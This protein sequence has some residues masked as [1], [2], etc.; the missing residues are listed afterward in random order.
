M[1]NDSDYDELFSD[2]EVED[3]LTADPNIF[4]PLTRIAAP[5]AQNLSTKTLYD[6][7]HEGEIDLCPDYQRE[8]VWTQ[9]KQMAVI[10]SIWSNLY[11]PPVLFNVTKDEK[12]G[13]DIRVCIDGKQRLT[14]ISRFLAGEIPY[15]HP[16]T[17]KLWWFTAP[18]NGRINRNQIPENEK[19]DF[20]NRTV[21]C[22]EYRNLT[23]AME[24][25]IFQRV[26]LGVPL[27]AAEKLQ[28]V[29]SDMATFITDLAKQ[30][31][32]IE[33]GLQD[34][35]EFDQ[36]RGRLYQN[37]AHLVYCVEG[38]PDERRFATS[39]KVTAWINRPEPV[40]K[41][42][43]S[44][45]DSTLTEFL[46]IASDE[47]HNQAFDKIKQR[48]APVEFI[49]IGVLLCQLRDHS[50]REKGKAL[51]SF[52][53][54]ARETFKD[55]RNNGSCVKAFWEFVEQIIEDPDYPIG[56]Q[57]Q[58]ASTSKAKG[59]KRKI[60]DVQT[61]PSRPGPASKSRSRKSRVS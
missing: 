1:G 29:S 32:W 59:K 47:K 35:V 20:L 34:Y 17:K 15:R 23:E 8:V 26:Q 2:D 50:R 27:T 49:F 42:L 61:S 11:V 46:K 43:K 40:S 44:M 7:I 4:K 22:V 18:S 54:M 48:V 14:S 28:A 38:L 56:L 55:I 45:V 39:A 19:E 24:R 31:V 33:G 57:T 52:R 13:D 6:M 16:I 58:P 30:H 51:Y 12:T 25:E 9:Q 37:L 3:V 53:K 5:A 36:K 10:D 60:E 41:Q 21:T